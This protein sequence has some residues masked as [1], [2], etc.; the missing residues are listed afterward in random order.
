MKVKTKNSAKLSKF[1]WVRK[2][3]KW[4]DIVAVE[5][6][7][8]S[9]TLYYTPG[10]KECYL[11]LTEKYHIILPNLNL[12]NLLIYI[13]IYNYEEIGTNSFFRIHFELLFL[14]KTSFPLIFYYFIFYFI[15]LLIFIPLLYCYSSVVFMFVIGNCQDIFVS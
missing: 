12:L 13:C 14:T 9:Q 10:L 7:G 11:C 8:K 6:T 2:K 5:C 1:L 4:R 15:I 3:E